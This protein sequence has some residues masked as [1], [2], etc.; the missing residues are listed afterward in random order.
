MEFGVE[1]L[2]PFI[3]NTGGSTKMPTGDTVMDVS[4][5]RQECLAAKRKHFGNKYGCA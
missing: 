5:A 1:N 2:K 3:K 4:R